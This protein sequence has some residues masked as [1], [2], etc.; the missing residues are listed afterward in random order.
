ADAGVGRAALAARYVGPG[1]LLSRRVSFIRA[2][3]GALG[4]LS[5]KLPPKKLLARFRPTA[6]A[7]ELPADSAQRTDK[8]VG[9][10]LRSRGLGPEP[11]TTRRYQHHADQPEHH[12][13]Q[14]LPQPQHDVG[15]ARQFPGEAVLGIPDQPGSRR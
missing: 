13:V 8:D 6:L 4:P 12:G 10:R 14:R 11:R 9:S 3:E 5:P 7:P 2:L 15:H 1:L